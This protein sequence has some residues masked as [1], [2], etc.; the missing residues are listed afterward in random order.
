MR[1]FPAAPYFSAEAAIEIFVISGS[2]NC[3][4]TVLARKI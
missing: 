1:S 4:G 3:V 2:D